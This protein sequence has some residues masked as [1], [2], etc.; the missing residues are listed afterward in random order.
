MIT[1]LLMNHMRNTADKP[2]DYAAARKNSRDREPE[3]RSP[4]DR[5]KKYDQPVSGRPMKPPPSMIP[6]YTANGHKASYDCLK[7]CL[8]LFVYLWMTPKRGFWF[9][10]TY[11]DKLFISGYFWDGTVW[12][13]GAVRLKFIDSYF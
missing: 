13:K 3:S 6:A 7:N 2:A 4:K 5:E 8:F 11:A 12:K 1:N 9:Y 10:P